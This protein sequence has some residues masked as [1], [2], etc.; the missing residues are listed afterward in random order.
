[1]EKVK[2]SEIAEIIGGQIMTRVKTDKPDEEGVV[3]KKVITPK[4]I[5]EYGIINKDELAEESVKDVID[6]N[7]FSH[8]GDIIIKLN[9]PFSCG[10]VTKETEDAIIPSF[11]AIIRIK[12]D[13]TTQSL[14]PDYLLA[15]LNSSECRRQ[16]EKRVFTIVMSYGKLRDLEIPLPEIQ[17]QHSIGMTYAETQFRVRTLKKIIELEKKKNDALISEVLKY[18]R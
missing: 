6:E 12:K 2:L 4:A 8:E 17:M 15:Y 1:M 3:T 5:E 14:I 10:L 16:I 13:I 18:E 9:T 11:C 7:K